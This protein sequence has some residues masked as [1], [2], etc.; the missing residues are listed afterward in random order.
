[1]DMS[2][3]AGFG[4]FILAAVCSGAFA[5]PQKFVKNF[6]WENTWGSFWFF[7]MVI[8]PVVV[9]PFLVKD[10]FGIW[11][12]A[13]SFEVI[14]TF[15]FGVFWGLG[16][17]TFGMG[18]SAIGLSLGFSIIMG[19]AIGVGSFLP[20]AVLYPEVLSTNAG[21]VSIAGIVVCVM[22]P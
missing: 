21:Y 14:K 9:T 8:I 2:L 5:F 3:I 17:I 4:L 13:G 18:I 16:C 10:V 22:G 12:A 20:L 7:T 19:L 15:V 11:S 6:P 1:M